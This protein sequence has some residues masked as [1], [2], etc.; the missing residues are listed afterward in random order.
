MPVLSIT[1]TY[2]NGNVLFQADL[3]TAFNSISTFLNTTGLDSTNIQTGGL[4]GTNLA[5]GTIGSAQIA[6]SAITSSLLASSAVGQAQR[7]PLGYQTSTGQVTTGSFSFQAGTTNDIPGLNNLMVTS[8]GRPVYIG[9]LPASSAAEI[10]L[11]SGS[12]GTI[13]LT[14]QILR[15]QFPASSSYIS[16]ANYNFRYFNNSGNTGQLSAGSFPYF[17][18]TP[19]AGTFTY[20]LSAG[21]DI[22]ST[23]TYSFLQLAAYEL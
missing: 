17:I 15:T 10:L 13:D 12:N 20:K 23:A 6:N 11:T 2:L 3:D 9:V 14:Q 19:G 18:D 5:N 21:I 1:K 4:L 7:A 8:I 22:N 16:I